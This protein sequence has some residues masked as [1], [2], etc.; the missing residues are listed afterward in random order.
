[1]RPLNSQAVLMSPLGQD[2]T[3]QSM[4]QAG[5]PLTRAAYL[6][7][8]GLTE[9][10]PT[11]SEAELPEE[12]QLAEDGLEPGPWTPEELTAVGMPEAYH[13]MASQFSSL[14][15]IAETFGG[16]TKGLEM[17]SQST[18]TPSSQPPE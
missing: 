12:F 16:S 2:P 9:P 1:M 3:V 11:E 17:L 4:I 5:L 7:A 18:P 13:P 8:V 15:E 6:Q 14:T 10:V